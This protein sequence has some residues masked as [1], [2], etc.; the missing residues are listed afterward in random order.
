MNKHTLK[1]LALKV[2]I[3]TVLFL[4]FIFGQ[5]GELSIVWQTL[6]WF[7]GVIY[8]GSVILRD[9]DR[10]Y[11]GFLKTYLEVHVWKRHVNPKSKSLYSKYISGVKSLERKENKTRWQE[12]KCKWELSLINKIIEESGWYTEKFTGKHKNKHRVKFRKGG[13]KAHIRYRNR[14]D[15]KR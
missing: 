6:F 1:R 9:L 5:G 14:T 15:R 7:I 4:L 3:P 11:Y 8:V 12:I 13:Q 2:V 10:K